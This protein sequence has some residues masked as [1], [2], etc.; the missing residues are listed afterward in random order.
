MSQQESLLMLDSSLLYLSG[1]CRPES[2][3]LVVS[4]CF[5]VTAI[6]F[7]HFYF[8][9]DS[10][11]RPPG[12]ASFIGHCAL[13][14]PLSFLLL[15]GLQAMQMPST[16]DDTAIS[17]CLFPTVPA[18]RTSFLLPSCSGWLSTM[19]LW[20]ASASW[21]SWVSST[22]SSMFPGECKRV[23]PFS[24]LFNIYDKQQHMLDCLSLT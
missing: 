9:P 1:G 22:T 18:Q 15:T 7:Q 4:V 10:P 12:L 2:M 19:R 24:H 16:A 14:H 23:D 17:V 8:T 3:G 6:V 20:H 21:P 11:V 13:E 5:L